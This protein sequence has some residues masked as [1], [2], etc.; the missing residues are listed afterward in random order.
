MKMRLVLSTCFVA[1][2]LCAGAQTT[3]SITPDAASKEDVKKLFDVM[4]SREQ[5]SQL[6][7]QVF[8]QMRKMNREEIKKRRPE[9]TE[10][11]LTR[12]DRQSED[13]IKNFPL[14]EMLNDMIPIY[15]RHFSKSEIEAL[16]A[17]YSSPPG[18]KFLHEMPAVTAETMRA[19]YPRIQAQVDAALKRAEEKS[20]SPQK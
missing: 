13:L 11:D 2:S 15:Q 17:F 16:T 6:M 12:M 7:Q 10:A 5:M 14:D 19:V 1:L 3:V 18:Q 20:D 9:I 8:A 4:A